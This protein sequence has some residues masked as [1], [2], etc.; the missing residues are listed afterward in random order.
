MDVYFDTS[1]WNHL[2]DHGERDKLIRLTQQRK[3][4][5]A[6][7]V[8]SVGE[9]LR[10]RDDLRRQRICSTMR[11][12][13]GCAPL[14]ERPFDVARA[15][16]QA[17]LQG[18]EDFPLP[19]TG[20]GD[21]LLH[22]M[23]DPTEL[24]PTDEIWKW[25]RNMDE[26]WTEFKAELNLLSLEPELDVLPDVVGSEA[27]LK[28]LCRLRPAEELGVSVSQMHAIYGKSDVWKGL[29]AMLAYM[30]KPSTTHAPNYRKHK[31]LPGARDLWQA[32]YLGVV[33]GFVTGDELMLDAISEI[34]SVALFRYPRFTESS[35]SFFD[36][37]LLAGK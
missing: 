36:R 6:A 34:S 2:E 5:V 29:G 3:Q 22:C 7:S 9:V 12:L 14:L 16:A 31:K 25:L 27:L 21:Y 30:I 23:S 35:D 4:R 8:I 17:V 26:S 24:R 19:R 33:E 11:T 28:S 15:A 37:F 10:I 13:H 32:P 18:Q 1:T 20:S